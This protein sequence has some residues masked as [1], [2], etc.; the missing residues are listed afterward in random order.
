MFLCCAA[1]TAVVALPRHSGVCLSSGMRTKAD[2]ALPSIIFHYQSLFTAS[3]ALVG[4]HVSTVNLA[5][6]SQRNEVGEAET[7]SAKP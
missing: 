7:L 1:T 6:K 3:D 5:A 2:V 4:E